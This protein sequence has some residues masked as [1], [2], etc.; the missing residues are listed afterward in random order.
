[1]L[2][3]E[4][5][6]KYVTDYAS[7]HL[8]PR[9][10]E[11]YGE[12]VEKTISILGD[13]DITELKPE[14]LGWM[15]ATLSQTMCDNTIRGYFTALRSIFRFCR[16]EDIPCFN[17]ERVQ[18]PKSEP[19]IQVY[20]EPIEVRRMIEAA[21]SLQNKLLVAIL[22]S[23]AMRV[24]EAMSLDRDQIENR[25]A[26][27]IGKGRKLR[28]IYIDR[29]TDKIL[30]EY[31]NTRNDKQVA[32]FVTRRGTR[33]TISGAH[34]RIRTV[35]QRAGINKKVHPHTFRHSCATD[36]LMNG[37]DIFSVA[38]VMGHSNIATTRRY[39]HI[40]NRQIRKNYDKYHTDA[41]RDTQK[42]E[43]GCGKTRSQ[44]AN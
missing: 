14:D 33:M 17:Y 8:C 3:S 5:F 7:F 23:S 4:A 21:N 24:S 35:R 18:I 39:L 26:Q 15:R 43:K 1:M 2:L 22:Y 19:S 12:G 29:S 41:L 6:H 20:L 38:E 10:I 42:I 36:M 16:R 13:K 44:R 34:S 40:A 11:L 32:L 31:L 25:S 30:K 37:A 27:V 9:T 28:T